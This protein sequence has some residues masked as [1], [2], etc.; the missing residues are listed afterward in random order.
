MFPTKT[1]KGGYGSYTEEDIS[2]MLENTTKK[3]TKALILFLSSTG[4]RAGVIPEL[5]LSH[6]T[7]YD[8]NCKQVVCYAESN[9]E[10]ITFMTPEASKAF[11]DYLEE[12]QQDNEKLKPEAPAFRKNYVIGSTPAET[13]LTETVRSA[14]NMSLKISVRKT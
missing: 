1:K 6:V 2:L 12:R 8:N 7:N 4:C 11:D 9:E 3:R 10:Y 5:K 14:I 13:M